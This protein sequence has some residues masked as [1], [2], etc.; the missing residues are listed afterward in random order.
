M[1]FVFR[2]ADSLQD[3]QKVGEGDCV[4]LIKKYIP[5]LARVHTS[6]WRAGEHVVDVKNL[7]RGTAIATFVD[8]RYPGKPTG[9]HAA[10]YLATAGAGFYAM[11]QWVKK[12]LIARR[13]IE[14]GRR[15]R[16]GQ[17]LGSLSDSAQA[18][19]VIEL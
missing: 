11:D 1:P 5:A 15:T 9:N 7:P 4:D 17:L 3:Q 6:R 18:F 12:P 13:R 16:D 10:F 19:Y 14:P 8:G 2:D